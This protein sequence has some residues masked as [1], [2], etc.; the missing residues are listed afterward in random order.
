[1]ALKGNPQRQ[2]LTKEWQVS[3][4]VLLLI[5]GQNLCCEIYTLSPAAF[6]PLHERSAGAKI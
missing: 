4:F 6:L 3:Q 1:M 5:F 2:Y